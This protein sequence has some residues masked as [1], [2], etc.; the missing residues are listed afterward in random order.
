MMLTAA[1]RTTRYQVFRTCLFSPIE[2]LRCYSLFRVYG[3]YRQDFRE[4]GL[5]ENLIIIIIIII[6]A[7]DDSITKVF[8]FV[9][10]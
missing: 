2:M 10:H 7:N 1:V 3:Y 5:C 6:T 9:N 4:V 8:V